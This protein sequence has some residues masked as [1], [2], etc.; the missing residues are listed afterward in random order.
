[1]IKYVLFYDLEKKSSSKRRL[2]DLI[3]LKIG[4]GV[5][6]KSRKCSNLF[7]IFWKKARYSENSF[8]I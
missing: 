7:F 5:M 4:A 3:K 8:R 2:C 1:M 6:A